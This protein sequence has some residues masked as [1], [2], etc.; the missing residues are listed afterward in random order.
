MGNGSL[1]LVIAVAILVFSSR[2]L[3]RAFLN[4]SPGGAILIASMAYLTGASILVLRD[5]SEAQVEVLRICCV[6]LP[7]FLTGY[8][9]SARVLGLMLEAPRDRM[10]DASSHA[11]SRGWLW[12]F[13]LVMLGV[14][15]TAIYVSGTDAILA[16]LYQF[17]FV[18]DTGVSVMELRM[19]FYTGEGGYFAPGYI[20]QLRDVLL[21]LS[22][23][24]LLF[25]VPRPRWQ[26]LG[27]MIWVV[28]LVALLMISSGGRGDVMMFLLATAYAAML[29]IRMK[30]ANRVTILA[31]LVFIVIVGGSVF[32]AM[33]STYTNRGYDDASMGGIFLD[34]VVTTVPSENVTT[35]PAWSKGAPSVGAGWISELSTILPGKKL[36]LST[37]LHEEMGGGDKGNSVLGMWM[38]VFFN[39]DWIL[40]TV[41]AFLIG[42][43]FAVYSHWV[44]SRRIQSPVAAICG[45]WISLT[46]V[47]VYSPFGFVL[48][49]PFVLSGVLWLITRQGRKPWPSQGV[50]REVATHG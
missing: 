47:N 42:V 33:T 26:M 41:V 10:P 49:G 1:L 20:K 17:I 13:F 9:G 8:F 6:F 45:L 35:F 31:P 30:V 12:A 15:A 22:A 3:L 39:F 23:M 25:S 18:G 46:L 34:R 50:H 27:L 11:T 29:A 44:N 21:P 32:G 14:V 4:P 48:Y 19:G 43:Y 38:D 37:L 28:P 5:G 2:A 7:C 40:G 16:A 24:L 36:V